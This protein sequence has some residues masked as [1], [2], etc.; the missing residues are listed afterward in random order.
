MDK[1]MERQRD[2]VE[3]TNRQTNR[4]LDSYNVQTQ[5]KKNR[6]GNALSTVL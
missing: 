4:Q 2:R 1:E 3:E 5:R 6:K